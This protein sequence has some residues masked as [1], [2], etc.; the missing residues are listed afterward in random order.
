MSIQEFPFP[1]EN[2]AL[3]LRLRHCLS[4]LGEA[5]GQSGLGRAVLMLHGGN[6]SSDTYTLPHGGLAAFL[7]DR[8]WDVWLLDYRCSPYVQK[9]LPKNPIGGSALAECKLFT[10]DRI[11]EVDVPAALAELTRQQSGDKAPKELSVMGHCVGS[12]TVALAIAR[13]K[14]ETVTNVVL[15][16]LGLFYEVP[17]NGWVKAEDYLIE[18]SLLH[19]PKCRGID[20]KSDETWPA[21]MQGALG[22]WPKAWLPSGDKKW[23]AMLRRLTFMFGQPYFMNA[24]DPTLREGALLP[25]FGHM[26]MGTY[27]HLGQMVRRGFAAEFNDPDVIDRS[28]FL[29]KQA[30]GP[31]TGDLASGP[32]FKDKRVTLITG[33]ENRLWHRDSID[34]MYEWLCNTAAGGTGQF[35]KQAYR[36]YGLQEIV[37]GVNA[38]AEIFPNIEQGLLGKPPLS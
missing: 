35:F 37:W 30:E 36:G 16:A 9:A 3:T 18:R 24:I 38:A 7:A 34:L 20:P 23:E 25:V 32:N 13:G 28:R 6:S 31:P 29:R 15:S 12:G 14:F 5:R 21:V 33:A 26:H 8:G 2:G 1:V 4:N 10:L 22:A 19:I 17:W 27:W 11:V